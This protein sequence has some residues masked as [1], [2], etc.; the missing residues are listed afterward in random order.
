MLAYGPMKLL[1]RLYP[2]V[3]VLTIAAG[4]AYAAGAH[5]AVIRTI[6]AECDARGA[7]HRGRDSRLEALFDGAQRRACSLHARIVAGGSAGDG[8]DFD[9]LPAEEVVFPYIVDSNSPAF[10]EGRTLRLFNSAWEETYTSLGDGPTSLGEPVY[11]ELPRPERPG[12]VWLESV[13]LEPGTNVLYGWYHF[14]PADLLCMTAPIIG[15][16]VSFDYG[17]TWEDRGPVINPQHGL[18]CDYDNGYFSGGNGDFS[19]ILDSEGR[20]F[21]FL[22]TSYSGPPEVQGI[23]VARSSA[24]DRGQPGTVYKY[25][26]GRWDEAALGGRFTPL[27]GTPTGWKGPYIES[28]W[29][30]SV[31]WNRHVNAYVALLNR[32]AGEQWAQEGVYITFSRDLVRWTPPRKIIEVDAWYPQVMGLGDDETDA[33]A[34]ETARIFVGGVS[35][36]VI[37]FRRPAS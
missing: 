23:G 34:G 13:W 26:N 19:V 10:R 15:A 36:F 11:V 12:A 22:F 16:A 1:R 2:V 20:Y 37:Q 27:F 28:F 35:T 33:L 7:F 5:R 32:T 9:L 4:L 25:Y 24:A 8:F 6:A 14:E 30:P 31:H 21:Y 3:A 29:G 18:D 17:L